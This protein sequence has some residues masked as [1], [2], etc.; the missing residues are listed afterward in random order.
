[1]DWHRDS[2]LPMIA[3]RHL[4]SVETRPPSE[5]QIGAHRIC[6]EVHNAPASDTN[7]QTC[8]ERQLMLLCPLKLL[9]WSRMTSLYSMRRSGLGE[10]F[11]ALHPLTN[12]C[13]FVGYYCPASPRSNFQSVL[14]TGVLTTAVVAVW[15]RTE[16]L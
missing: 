16:G 10:K 12:S 1:M 4:T 11:Y 2:C 13:W 6:P 15:Q 3:N 14:L 5:I 7:L 9:R 8:H